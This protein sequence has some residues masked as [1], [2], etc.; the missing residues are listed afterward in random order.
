MIWL[1]VVV[2][3]LLFVHKDKSEIKYRSVWIQLKKG[4]TITIYNFYAEK[5]EQSERIWWKQ[6][7]FAYC[8]CVFFCFFFFFYFLLLFFFSLSCWRI[9]RFHS[10]CVTIAS[11]S[12]SQYRIVVYVIIINFF[13]ICFDKWTNCLYSIETVGLCIHRL[14]IKKKK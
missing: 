8:V 14:N 11:N 12:H 4:D 1:I 6:K 7:L 2:V 5:S 3:Y 13:R 10:E 9:V